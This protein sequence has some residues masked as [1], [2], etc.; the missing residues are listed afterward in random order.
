MNRKNCFDTVRHMAA[1]MVLFSHHYALSGQLEPYILNFESL[2]GIAVIIFFSISGFLISKSAMN[3]NDFVDFM[4][5]RVKRIFPALIPCSLI[6]FIVIGGFVNRHQPN[7]YFTA[8]VFKNII[9]TISLN[10]FT[11]DGI[12]DNFIHP[13]INGS[14]WTLPLE[15]LCYLITGLAVATWKRAEFFTFA[16][17]FMVFMSI[18]LLINEY[19]ILVFSIPLW[20]FFLRGS[21]F[22]LGAVLALNYDKWKKKNVCLFIAIFLFMYA[23]ST[24]GK[25]IEYTVT[26]YILVSFMTILICTSFNDFLV[27]GRFDFSYGIYIYAF[28]VQ[29]III[30]YTNMPFFLS[31]SV[32]AAITIIL[33]ACSWHFVE[34]KALSKYSKKILLKNE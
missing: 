3:S 20:L 24:Y 17:I 1:L 34:K 15:F 28:P 32:S 14:L 11:N 22:F 16:F 6:M 13:G 33:A 25:K 27:N 2:G 12:S 4:S 19:Q 7:E 31:M 26:C 9:S 29:Q 18:I 5:K 23:F 10:G 8:E 30:N 21:S